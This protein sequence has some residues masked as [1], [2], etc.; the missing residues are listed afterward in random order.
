MRLIGTLINLI[1]LV[2]IVIFGYWLYATFVSAPGAP[3][4]DEINS[5]LPG[6]MR[7]WS[8]EQVLKREPTAK[9]PS[10]EGY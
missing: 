1:I 7:R 6:A 8:C 4:W 9:P 10:C 2:L 3:Y 5:N